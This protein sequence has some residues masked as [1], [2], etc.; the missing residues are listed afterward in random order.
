M[1][2]YVASAETTWDR[3]I[4]FA[5]VATFSNVSEW[6]P[7][8]PRARSLSDDPLAVGAKF[9]VVSE[10][11]G[12]E[13]ELTYE[14]IELEAPHRVLLRAET[15]TLASLDEMTFDL[16]PG[17]GTIVTYDA[18]LTMKGAAKLLELPMR[19]AFNRIGDKAKNG[20]RARLEEPQPD[21]QPR[22]RETSDAPD[23]TASG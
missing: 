10:F 12:R 11:M 3:E 13:S 19:L 23:P 5:Y 4:A 8:I 6:D 1:P 14:T 2:R 21:I 9:E 7:G 17:G 22:T 15:S 20:L 16:R 18:E